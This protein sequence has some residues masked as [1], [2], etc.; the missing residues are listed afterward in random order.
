M[1]RK[2]T[3]QPGASSTEFIGTEVEYD[4]SQYMAGPVK[5]GLCSM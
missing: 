1:V 4:Q 3:V 5:K 2:A